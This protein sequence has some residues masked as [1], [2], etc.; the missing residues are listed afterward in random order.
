MDRRGF[1][2]AMVGGVSLAAART[3]PFR[4]FSFPSEI[5][6]VHWYDDWRNFDLAKVPPV[7]LDPGIW[8]QVTTKSFINGFRGTFL[9]P[10]I[11]ENYEDPV[12]IGDLCEVDESKIRWSTREDPRK[13]P[14]GWDFKEPESWEE[15]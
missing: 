5:K 6:V 3:W 15:E 11:L 8:E 13:F 2:G 4:V 9:D 14:D 12:G 10:T 1:L 7:H